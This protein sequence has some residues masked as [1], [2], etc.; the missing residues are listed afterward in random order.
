M[1]TIIVNWHAVGNAFVWGCIGFSLGVVFLQ[2]GD[3]ISRRRRYV[4]GLEARVEK[5]A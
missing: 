1:T 5:R 4:K 3:S 2:V